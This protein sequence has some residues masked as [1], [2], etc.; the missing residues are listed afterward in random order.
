MKPEELDCIGEW[1]LPDDPDTRVPGSM[2]FDPARGAHIELVGVLIPDEVDSQPGRIREGTIVHGRDGRGRAITLLDALSTREQTSL[3]NDEEK[4][5]QSISAQTILVGP[6]H[7]QMPPLFVACDFSLTGLAEWADE[8]FDVLRRLSRTDRDDDAGFRDGIEAHRPPPLELP[9]FDGRLTLWAG[10]SSG[11]SPTH[12]EYTVRTHWHFEPPA[13]MSLH[14]FWEHVVGPLE[15]LHTLLTGDPAAP[16]D[17]TLQLPLTKEPDEFPLTLDV[18]TAWGKQPDLEGGRS[19]EWPVRITD[20]AD[21]FESIIGQWLVLYQELRQALPQF[22]AYMDRKRD[23]YMDNRFL[24][25]T[26][27]AETYH[28]HRSIFPDR[29]IDE[30]E[31]KTRLTATIKQAPKEWREWMNQ[32]LQFAYEPSFAERLKALANY[33][34]PLGETA[35]PPKT[36][37][38]LVELRN[39]MTHGLKYEDTDER[40]EDILL[41]S[42]KLVL[43]VRACLL[44][45]LGFEEDELGERFDRDPYSRHVANH[46]PR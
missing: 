5:A 45:D 18:T 10:T 11:N 16:I 28:R 1:W 9:V 24:A 4:I 20:I 14:Q 46:Q 38:R 21:R 41:L 23:L 35:L 13:P 44:R 31:M 33:I 12:V 2:R 39:Q 26:Q 15:D 30:L 40:L 32:R 3:V 43:L 37:R 42:G 7:P 25:L 22:F 17:V 8:H 6:D 34:G 29:A 27:A 36:I 19:W